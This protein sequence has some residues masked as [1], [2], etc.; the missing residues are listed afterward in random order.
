MTT[1]NNTT[2]EREP[3]EVELLLPWYAAGTLDADQMRQVEAALAGD[4]ELASRYEWVRAEFAQE[5]AIGDTAG[6]PSSGDV[7]T[8]FAKIDALPV[9]RPGATFAARVAEFFAGVSPRVLAFSAAAAV[10]VIILQ[11][12]VLAGFVFQQNNQVGYQTASAPATASGEG[13]Y[14]LIRFQPQATAADITSFL[15]ANKL[16]VVSGPAGGQLYRVRVGATKLA[17][18]DLAHIVNTLQSDKVVAFIAK[19]D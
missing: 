13:S 17:S 5:T 6:G 4:P 18:A 10:L 16:S 8:L 19:A 1:A 15:E 2:R 9:R 7:R 11:A 14:V 3:S 12:G